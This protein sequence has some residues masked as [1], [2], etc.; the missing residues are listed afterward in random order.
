MNSNITWH[1]HSVTRVE[2]ERL[3]GHR[4]CVIWFTG[5]SASGK[6]TIANLVDQKLCEREVRTYLLDGDNVRYGLNASPDTLQQRHGREFASRFG[7]G[8]SAEDREENIRR[9]GAVAK[10]FSE[11]GVVAL[12]AFISPYRRDRDGVRAT[13][14]DGD[15]LEI[16][17]DTPIEICEQ[18]DPKGLYKKV[19][20]GEIKG[21]TG[22][23]DPYEAPVAPELRLEGGMKDAETL[24]DEVISYLEKVG[25]IPALARC[26]TAREGSVEVQQ[27]S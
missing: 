22:I 24:A 16:F 26:G 1:S 10:L 12:T 14:A 8:F 15:F 25:V 5:L 6:S 18:R 19:R 4:G 23:D 27:V 2:R 7:L 21:F 13:L 3:N 11:A 9:I 20:A 17:I